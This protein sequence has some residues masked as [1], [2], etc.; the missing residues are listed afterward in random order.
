M[1]LAE[2]LS[3]LRADPMLGEQTFAVFEA[4]V[5]QKRPVAEVAAEF[6]LKEN[7]VYQIKNRLMRR[8][9][10]RIARLMRDSGAE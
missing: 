9:E 8:L 2:A 10:G 4:Y 3:E 7:G 6:G 5:I 1:L